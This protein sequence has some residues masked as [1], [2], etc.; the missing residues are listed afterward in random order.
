MARK[1]Y[2]MPVQSLMESADLA[3]LPAAGAGI[4]IRL[5]LHAW[6]T[7]PH[8][9]PIADHELRAIARAHQATWCEH[10]ALCMQVV[11]AWR[12]QALSY[13]NERERKATTLKFA[14]RLGGAARKAK[15]IAQAI[16]LSAPAPS[17]PVGP[18][19]PSQA[20]DRYRTPKPAKAP[21]TLLT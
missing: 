7:M 3:R 8:P 18:L 2:P 15:A 5:C 14:A 20:P 12:P 19:I 13:W 6:Q 9:L 11:N 10:K 16:D 17:A 4:V 1:I 21:A